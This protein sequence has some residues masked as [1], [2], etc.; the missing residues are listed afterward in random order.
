MNLVDPKI[1][2]YCVNHS[3]RPS[4]IAK[5]LQ[6]FT[7][8]NVHGSQMLIG[9]ME[10]SVLKS[11]IRL[12]RLETVVEFGTYTGYSALCMAE[13]LP[14]KGQ[15]FTIDVNKETSAIAKKYWDKSLH[16]KKIT[17]ILKPGLEAMKDLDGKYDLIFID[18]DKDNYS[19]YLKWS[20]EH[21]SEKGIIVV[22]NTLWSG[23]VLESD[24]DKRT[25]AIIKHN[26]L[27]ASLNGY[28]KTL[29]PIRDGMFLIQKG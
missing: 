10:A 17:Q 24:G 19:N 15:V 29:L 16:G 13:S 20:L 1:E 9:E 6:D 18:A 26:K 3:S 11:L 4:E 28:T 23:R 7:R 25:E 8:A 12:G 14:E 27:A 2:E 21:L 5:E 22:D